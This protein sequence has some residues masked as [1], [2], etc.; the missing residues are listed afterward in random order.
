MFVQLG[1]HWQL[2][3][4][5]RFSSKAVSSTI[6]RASSTHSALSGPQMGIALGAW[7]T[8]VKLKLLRYN[9]KNS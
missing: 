7:Q 5:V 3:A 2:V 6:S 9:A 1:T 8:G 4:V